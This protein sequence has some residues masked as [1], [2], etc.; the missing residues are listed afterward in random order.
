MESIWCTIV[1]L[2]DSFVMQRMSRAKYTEYASVLNDHLLSIVNADTLPRACLK[3]RYTNELNLFLY[4]NWNIY[5]SVLATPNVSNTLKTW[6]KVGISRFH[7][8]LAQIGLPLMEAKQNYLNMN[9]D[10]KHDLIQMFSTEIVAERFKL[11]GLVFGSFVADIGYRPRFNALDMQLATLATLEDTDSSKP[12][13]VLFLEAMCI[14]NV[15]DFTLFQQGIEKAKCMLK[16]MRN[17]VQNMIDGGQMHEIGPFIFLQLSDTTSYQNY[18]QK[19]ASIQLLVHNLQ[20]AG[21]RARGKGKYKCYPWIV[22]VPCS[23]NDLLGV[24]VQPGVFE[25]NSRNMFHEV[26]RVIQI[27]LQNDVE[28]DFFDGWVIR[29]KVTQRQRFIDCLLAVSDYPD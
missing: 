10:L 29:V 24:G 23:Y 16:L 17:H 12:S 2:T 13:V 18:F 3:V 28:Q 1:G 7:Q 15:H 22:M 21:I 25:Y 11:P 26:F 27:R 14:L 20:H 9:I 5:E 4:R 19:P 6:S 8:L